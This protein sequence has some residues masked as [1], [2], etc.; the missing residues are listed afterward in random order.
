MS[1][2]NFK[3]CSCY[4]VNFNELLGLMLL[5]IKKSWH[6]SLSPENAHDAVSTLGFYGWSPFD[7]CAYHLITCQLN[8][9]MQH[10][11]LRGKKCH[12]LLFYSYSTKLH[13]ACYCV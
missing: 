6:M 2:V 11:N 13:A 12:T 5:H 8:A 10:L 1:H 4:S 9:L 7:I 3:K